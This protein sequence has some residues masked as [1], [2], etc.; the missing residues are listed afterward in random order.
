MF[1][2][3]NIR[4]G[5]VKSTGSARIRVGLLVVVLAYKEVLQCR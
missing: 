2:A 3:L 4:V 5:L 1:N